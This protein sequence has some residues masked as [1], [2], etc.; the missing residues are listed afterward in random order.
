M[1]KKFV[2]AAAVAAIMV[3][4]LAGC[5]VKVTNIAVPE[6][7]VVEKGESITLPVNFGT[8]DA[9]AK[10]R[11]YVNAR[12]CVYNLNYHIVWCVKYRRKVLTP[13]IANSLVADIYSIANEK[14]FTVIEATAL[15]CPNYFIRFFQHYHRNAMSCIPCSYSNKSDK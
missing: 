13:K 3:L 2:L 9:P 7:A 4:G 1:K 5:G 10:S 12:T 6:T 11:P 8:D 15:S 14:G